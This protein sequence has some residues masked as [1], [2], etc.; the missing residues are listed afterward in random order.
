[1]HR[2]YA[3]SL[4]NSILHTPGTA[5]TGYHHLILTAH[6]VPNYG[7]AGAGAPGGPCVVG[8]YHTAGGRCPCNCHNQ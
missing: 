2:K 5:Y 3:W 7:G 6:G 4:Q 8:Y 1:S